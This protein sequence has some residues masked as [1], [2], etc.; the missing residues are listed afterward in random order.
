MTPLT[1]S[2]ITV[3]NRGETGHRAF[4]VSVHVEGGGFFAFIVREGAEVILPLAQPIPV[5]SVSIR[6]DSFSA[7]R[8]KYTVS[9]VGN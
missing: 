9:L 2:L 4:F 7:A 6:C 8:C 5:T 1:T 3:A